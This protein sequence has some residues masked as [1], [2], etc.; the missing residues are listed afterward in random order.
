MLSRIFPKTFDNDY[1]GRRLAIWLFVAAMLLT[2]L[3]GAF[4]IAMTRQTLP[5]ADGISLDNLGATGTSLAVSLTALLGL[6]TLIL[7]V[8]GIVVLIRYRAMIPFMFICLLVL[9]ICNRILLRVNPI[10]RTAPCST[11]H[12]YACGGLH[13]MAHHSGYYVSWAIFG[14]TIL[15]LVLSL[16]RRSKPAPALSADG[17][18]T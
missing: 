4:V 15:G 10:V 13:G 14:M 11:P 8:Q 18:R 7:P 3:Q 16:M 17:N 6:F 5:T 1:R 2:G 12:S 9:D